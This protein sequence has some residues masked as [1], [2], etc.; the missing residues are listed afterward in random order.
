[1]KKLQ[2]NNHSVGEV[3]E[4]KSE[5]SNIKMQNYMMM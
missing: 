4:I 3:F 5:D 1:M 2:E